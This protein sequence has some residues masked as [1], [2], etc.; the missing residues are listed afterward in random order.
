MQGVT[1]GPSGGFAASGM[2]EVSDW[3]LHPAR[4][5]G[6]EVRG[7][8]GHGGGRGFE[9]SVGKFFWCRRKVIEE[10]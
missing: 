10:K 7:W 9:R 1:G 5:S 8:K 6:V 4:H 2:Q 3:H